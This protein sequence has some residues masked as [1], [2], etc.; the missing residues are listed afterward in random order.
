MVSPQRYG[1][2]NEVVN[3]DKDKKIVTLKDGKVIK[4]DALISTLPLDITLNWLGKPD[5]SEGLSRR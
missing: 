5:W 1:P 3:L 2:D 4:Y